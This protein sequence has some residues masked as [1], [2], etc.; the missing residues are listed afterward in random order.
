VVAIAMA[1]QSP[2]IV[3]ALRDELRADG[4]VAR[5]VLAVVVRADL[6]SSCWMV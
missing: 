1:A 2:A 4:P 6:L 3:V 5:T